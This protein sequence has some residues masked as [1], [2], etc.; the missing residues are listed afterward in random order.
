LRI[1]TLAGSAVVGLIL[2][3]SNVFG[4]TI[5]V[6][7]PCAAPGTGSNFIV[8]CP[9]ETLTSVLGGSGWILTSG[10]VTLGWGTVKTFVLDNTSGTLNPYT[11]LNASTLLT[12]T[13]GGYQFF[14][15]DAIANAPDSSAPPGTSFVPNVTGSGASNS[16]YTSGPGFA[17]LA[18]AGTTPITFTV[19][20]GSTIVSIASGGLGTTFSD[21]STITPTVSVTYTYIPGGI[22][23]VPEP[24][25]VM[26]LGSAL[27]GMFFFGRNR[28]RK[29]QMA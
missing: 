10:V 28:I 11:G 21:G 17:L 22:N 18:A 24:T 6:N 1:R 2:A 27:I 23:G 12:L 20:A 15:L 8:A 3:A 25:T 4:N 7:G 13:D 14:S 9:V 5:T 16:V 19:T 26:L 29:T